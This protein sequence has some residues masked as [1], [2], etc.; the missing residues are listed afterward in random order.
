M[1]MFMV[2]PPINEWDKANEESILLG[3][4]ASTLSASPVGA[5]RSHTRGRIDQ[6]QAW[7]DKGYRLR[8][9]NV[10]MIEEKSE[11]LSPEILEAMR[12]YIAEHERGEKRA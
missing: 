4:G 6:V 7:F 5:W 8:R 10:T 2:V 1:Q 11:P 9:V 12:K 3:M